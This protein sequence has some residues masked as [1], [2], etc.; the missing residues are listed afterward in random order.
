MFR[1]FTLSLSGLLLVASGCVGTE[2][3]NGQKQKQHTAKVELRLTDGDGPFANESFVG[4]DSDGSQLTITNAW[5]SVDRIDLRLAA[6]VS[7]SEVLATSSVVADDEDPFAPTCTD[8]DDILRIEG[9]FWVDLMTGE[10]EP[11]L[12]MVTLPDGTYLGGSVKL[13]PRT[14]ADPFG[15]VAGD[16]TLAADGALAD[17]SAFRMALRL[18][19]VIPFEGEVDFAEGVASLLLLLDVESW[20]AE[21]PVTACAEDGDLTVDPD[22]TYVISDGRDG[23]V[24]ASRVIGDALKLSGRLAASDE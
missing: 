14:P 13:H 3:G 21:L 19:D 4:T 17:G 7:C 11:P 12:D 6:G 10:S 9:P 22:G 23:C 20:F 8:D 24:S 2:T 1:L 18:T 15:D 16:A 5:A